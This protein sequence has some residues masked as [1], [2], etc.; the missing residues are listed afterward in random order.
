MSTFSDTT[1]ALAICLTAR[2]PVVLWGDPG[3]GKTASIENIAKT[4]GKLLETVIASIREPADFAGL[5]NVVDGRTVM[6]PPD[7]ALNVAE[8]DGDAMIFLD[9]ISTA[10]PATQ[11]ALLRPVV[12]NV[13][14]SLHIGNNVSWVM[15]ANPPE[16]AADGWDLAIPMA[17]RLTHLDWDLPADVVS[18]GFSGLG[19][20]EIEVP[21]P[22]QK[23]LDKSIAEA[24][25]LVGAFLN[26]RPDWKSRMPQESSEA[27]R[28]WPSP[29]SWENA[30]ILYGYANAAGVPK[31]VRR[32]LV[33]GTVGDAACGEFLVYID[34]LDLPDPEAVLAD[35]AH[36][37]VPT[38]TDKV[39]A[40]GASV[41]AAVQQNMTN[42]RWHAVGDVMERMVAAD[43]ADAAVAMGR[44]W[45][46]I[47]PS[48]KVMPNKSNLQSLIPVLERAKIIEKL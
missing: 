40:V 45:M 7:W 6:V 9:E 29:R 27:G 14:G 16:S 17:N 3:E 28:A 39:Y 31:T 18:D 1:A 30:G 38:R 15:A 13:V 5:P 24:K 48:S 36:W 23:T 44:K 22:D 47:R 43:K 4:Q 19:W 42:K 11:A 21:V 10:P 25:L 20:P 32:M 46:Q 41:L 37:E 12:S 33:G 8:H 35:P 34:E 26:A 2:Q